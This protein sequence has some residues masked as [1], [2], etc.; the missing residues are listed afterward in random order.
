MAFYRGYAGLQIEGEMRY[1]R[2]VS[3]RL[4]R[5]LLP[6]AGDWRTHRDSPYPLIHSSLHLN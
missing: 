2:S 6:L 1:A 4:Y 5:S 3:L